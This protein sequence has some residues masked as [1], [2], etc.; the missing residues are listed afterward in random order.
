MNTKLIA[1]NPT[2]YHNY[3]IENKLEAGIVLSGTEIKSIR[4]GK[5][6]MKD[7][8]AIIKNGE[9]FIVGMHISPY[10]HGNIFNKDPLRDRKLLL[11][12]REINKLVGLI[13]QKGYTL[14]PISLYFSGNYIKVELG[15]GKGKKLYDKRQDIAKRDAEIRMRKQMAESE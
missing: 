3:T 4:S 14:V 7:C 13:K 10:E 2:A 11:N 1:K 15:I 6:N 8:Y 9:V 12:K 5:V